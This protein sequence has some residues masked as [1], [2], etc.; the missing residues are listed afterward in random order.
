MPRAASASNRSGVK[1]SPAVG[2]ATEPAFWRINGLIIGNVPRIRRRACRRYR[3]AAAFRRPRAM[4]ASNSAPLRLK[5]SSTSPPWRPRTRASSPWPNSRASSCPSR[6]AGWAK[7][8][9]RSAPSLLCRVTSTRTGGPPAVRDARHP[10]SR[11]RMTLVS[12]NDTMSPLRS[13]SGRS[14]KHRCK[15]SPFSCT[16]SRRAESRGSAGRSAIR[17]GGRLKPNRSVSI[18]FRL[19]RNRAKGTPGHNCLVV[20]VQLFG[21][22]SAIIE[23]GLNRRD[24]KNIVL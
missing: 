14:R 16:T 11:A 9:N 1:C 8:L 10:P 24:G 5:A 19:G 13:K 7:A 22:H 6:R 12:L 21:S 18:T 4:A 2:A 3:A 15:I 17:P 23:S 20:K